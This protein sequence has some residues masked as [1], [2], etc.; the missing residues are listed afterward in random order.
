MRVGETAPRRQ[1]FAPHAPSARTIHDSAFKMESRRK[2]RR[3]LVRP[4]QA[5]VAFGG[6]MQ[7]LGA[8]RFGEDTAALLTTA[9]DEVELFITPPA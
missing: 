1:R 5:A 6:R 4:T 7:N 9:A 3:L 8:G 2:E